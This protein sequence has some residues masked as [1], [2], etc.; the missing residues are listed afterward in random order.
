[1]GGRG[2]GCGTLR[3]RRYP[4]RAGAAAVVGCAGG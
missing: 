2:R 3:Y 1:M 4:L